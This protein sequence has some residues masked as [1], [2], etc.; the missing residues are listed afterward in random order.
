MHFLGHVLT[1][2]QAQGKKFVSSL[3]GLGMHRDNMTEVER[4]NS[5][6]LSSGLSH[7]GQSGKGPVPRSL[8]SQWRFL[9]NRTKPLDLFQ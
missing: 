1:A 8:R 3:Q 9:S 7:E 4:T 6:S 5:D 2:V